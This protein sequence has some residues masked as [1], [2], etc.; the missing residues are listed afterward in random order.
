MWVSEEEL[1]DWKIQNIINWIPPF[2]DVNFRNFDHMSAP[3]FYGSRELPFCTRNSIWLSG[4][5]GVE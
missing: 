5:P 3:E 4:Q 1:N 2:L